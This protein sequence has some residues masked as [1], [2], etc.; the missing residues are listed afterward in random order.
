MRL[1]T[2]QK[3]SCE[4]NKAERQRT[5]KVGRF[6]AKLPGRLLVGLV[7]GELAVHQNSGRSVGPRGGRGQASARRSKLEPDTS[8]LSKV[9][10]NEW[11]VGKAV[12]R[13]GRRP[14]VARGHSQMRQRLW[15]RREVCRW[16]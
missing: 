1:T 2:H 15:P 9:V 16:R 14:S 5:F 11:V 7:C 10:R 12:L 3:S 8:K 13:E 6:E 4:V